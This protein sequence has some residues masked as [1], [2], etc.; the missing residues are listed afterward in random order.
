MQETLDVLEW[1]QGERPI[2][3]VTSATQQNPDTGQDSLSPG[4]KWDVGVCFVKLF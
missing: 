1:G 3:R 2:K 4:V